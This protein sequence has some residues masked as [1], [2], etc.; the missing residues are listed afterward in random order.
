MSLLR[1]IEKLGS[2]EQQL[3]SQ[4][5]SLEKQ[6]AT[7]TAGTSL[8]DEERELSS[9]GIGAVS[10]ISDAVEGADS[11]NDFGREKRGGDEKTSEV[12]DREESSAADQAIVSGEAMLPDD[13]LVR[14]F[15]IL[16]CKYVV[17]DALS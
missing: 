15:Q 8:E 14:R 5:A 4:I 9:L 1:E 16:Q 10:S 2:N 12:V 3:N 17:R 11:E 7:A 6:L 13:G